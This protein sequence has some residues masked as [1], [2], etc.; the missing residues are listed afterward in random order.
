MT[1]QVCQ[2]PVADDGYGEPVHKESGLYWHGDTKG[3]AG[4]VAR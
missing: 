1:C 4:H 3:L 2:E